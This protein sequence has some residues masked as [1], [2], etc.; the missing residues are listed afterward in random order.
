MLYTSSSPSTTTTTMD[1]QVAPHPLVSE[2]VCASSILFGNQSDEENAQSMEGFVKFRNMKGTSLSPNVYHLLHLFSLDRMKE[3][4]D[5]YLVHA[6]SDDQRILTSDYKYLNW[7]SP[8]FELVSKVMGLEDGSNEFFNRAA[9]CIQP[10]AMCVHENCFEINQD[11]LS[12]ESIK[13]DSI[14]NGIDQFR[15]Y[16]L[17]SGLKLNFNKWNKQSFYETF[18]DDFADFVCVGYPREEVY[19]ILEMT[20]EEHFGGDSLL[21]FSMM[22]PLLERGLQDSVYIDLVHRGEKQLVQQFEDYQK[23]PKFSELLVMPELKSIY[24]E[25][26]ALLLRCLV[27]P[28]NSINLRNVSLHGFISQSEFQDCYLSFLLLIIPT[29]SKK[30][31]GHLSQTIGLEKSSLKRPIIDL[32]QSKP[33]LNMLSVNNVSPEKFIKLDR[34]EEIDGLLENSA[35]II[36][37][38]LPMWKKAFTEYF[39]NKSYYKTISI[40]FPLF[41]HAIRRIF[42]CVNK[43]EGRLLTAEKNSLY[44][45]LDILLTTKSIPSYGIETN[46]IFPILGD[47]LLNP[48][49]DLLIWVESPR[50]RDLVSHGNIK[51]DSIPEALM[52]E[53]VKLMLA[54]IA[55]F[56][57]RRVIEKH[58]D[59]SYLPVAV[60]QSISY[61]EDDYDSPFHSMSILDRQL[62]VNFKLLEEAEILRN[63]PQELQDLP[64]YNDIINDVIQQDPSYTKLM[65]ISKIMK[66]ELISLI[67]Y[68]VEFFK[69]TKDEMTKHNLTHTH[70]VTFSEKYVSITDSH[71]SL[72]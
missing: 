9:E 1:D 22:V 33:V 56:D 19:R 55:K 23:L 72:F 48:I 32:S 64:T 41:E 20:L 61:F 34:I 15:Q 59:Y 40:I 52:D 70:P 35:F 10:I 6:T 24:G 67:D 44:T 25:D 18:K 38:W 69:L 30:T 71:F 29:L 39:V 37:E 63:I 28:L 17:D 51:V 43:C 50:V 12:Q 57:V 3:L 27:G 53:I 49:F 31:I 65:E 16:V 36:K 2:W 66:D 46:A 42:V 62:R 8:A 21:G 5:V 7:E 4:Q 68:V 47:K 54:T 13:N 58:E 26:L 11:M 45:T 14:A 60:Q